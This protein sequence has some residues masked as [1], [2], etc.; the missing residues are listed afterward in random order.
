MRPR[1]I[2]YL[3]GSPIPN[4]SRLVSRV[5]GPNDYQ[6]NR[7]HGRRARD[8]AGYL[9]VP[10]RDRGA[11]A[12]TLDGVPRHA[13]PSPS[14]RWQAG[15]TGEPDRRGVARTRFASLRR[16]RHRDRSQDHL[17]RISRRPVRQESDELRLRPLSTLGDLLGRPFHSS[18]D[19]R[20]VD[21]GSGGF[22][23]RRR[24]ARLRGRRL[25]PLDL[26]L[27]NLRD[28]R[29]PFASC[30][31]GK[32]GRAFCVALRSPSVPLIRGPE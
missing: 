27:E 18:R 16:R 25:D 31:T 6:R 1:L 32:G 7:S 19:R 20:R 30:R 9:G 4:S 28:D 22:D 10:L 5:V 8:V 12:N 24:V 23:D 15:T 3:R 21:M 17:L 26:L 29:R 2:G 14:S 11:H 13:S